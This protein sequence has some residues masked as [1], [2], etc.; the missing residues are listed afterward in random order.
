MSERPPNPGEFDDV[1]EH[2]RRVAALE[3]GGP[4]E[5]VRR[6][7]LEHAARLAAE[8][9]AAG[10]AAVDPRSRDSSRN[11][12][13]NIGDARRRAP[14]QTWWRPAALGTL[15]AAGLAGLLIAPQ[16]LPPRESGKSAS[17]P[18]G[19]PPSVPPAAPESGAE[20]MARNAPAAEGILT[21]RQ[22]APAAASK[23]AAQD[24]LVVQDKLQAQEPRS[25]A[26]AASEGDAANAQV[27]ADAKLAN[28]AQGAAA[29]SAEVSIEARRA[30]SQA[31]G[32][33]IASA[34]APAPAPALQSAVPM[35]AARL[36]DPAA[37]LRHAAGSG[38]MPAL[39]AALERR[40]LIDARDANGRTALMLAAL[41]GRGEAVDELLTAGADPNAADVQGVTPLQAALNGEQTDI[42]AALR[43]AGAR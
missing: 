1:D 19:A 13:V 22:R 24:A 9:V 6:A 43:R 36:L 32:G 41:H 27:S 23:A 10:S 42:A 38:D 31:Y 33:A 7:V 17:A 39:R 30:P 14:R 18:A 4:S 29:D 16:F 37:E 11:T 28:N 40:P 5:S 26:G 8:R 35:A 12:V 21:K 20:R 3:K 15:A 2:Y 34:A 25:E